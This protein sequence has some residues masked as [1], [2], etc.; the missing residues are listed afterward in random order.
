M[1][2]RWLALA[3]I[4]A[5]VGYQGWSYNQ[6][7]GIPPQENADGT[8]DYT[9][10]DKK[11]NV[12]GIRAKPE[13][14]E[15]VLRFPK[16]TYIFR[17]ETMDVGRF[18][19]NGVSLRTNSQANKSLLFNLHFDTFRFLGREASSL[20]NSVIKVWLNSNYLKYGVIAERPGHRSYAY[21]HFT[22]NVLR[23]AKDKELAP[24]VYKL[25]QA[26]R[27]E[28]RQV[29]EEISATWKGRP[30]DPELDRECY[31]SE[32]AMRVELHSPSGRPVGSGLCRF[33]DDA[34]TGRCAIHVWFPQNRTGTIRTTISQITNLAE[35]YSKA[36][37]IV[38]AATISE[39]EK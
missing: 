24:G 14:K 9:L 5:F 3:A 26:T 39:G 2:K 35:I 19:I 29:I 17:P 37:D 21:S 1:K 32:N 27:D 25:R 10:V 23:C 11:A 20:D 22:S 18:E 38:T 7:L 15:W 8:I 4:V 31:L 6:S 12:N 36:V 33:H 30:L 34:N 28:I 16:D 13:R